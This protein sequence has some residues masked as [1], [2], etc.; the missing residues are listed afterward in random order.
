MFKILDTDDNKCIDFKEFIK[1]HDL[2]GISV[3]SDKK[4]LKEKFNEICTDNKKYIYFDEVRS[5]SFF[6]LLKSLDKP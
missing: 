1:G 6:L 4:L 5:N 3:K 2:I